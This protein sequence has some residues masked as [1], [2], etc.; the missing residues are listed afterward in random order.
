MSYN[1]IVLLIGWLI[2][3]AIFLGFIVL[4]RYIQHRERMAMISRGL[5]PRETRRQRRNRGILR[6]G[7]ITMMVGLT[8]LVGLY[9]VGFLLPSNLAATPLHIGPWLLPGLIPFGVG[10]ALTGSYYL[11]QNSQSDTDDA[12]DDGDKREIPKSFLLAS[13]KKVIETD[14]VRKLEPDSCGE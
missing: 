5:H 10:L 2:A 8:L 11:E 3:L 14:T 13:V 4:L 12:K 1:A 6:A 7:L 9:P